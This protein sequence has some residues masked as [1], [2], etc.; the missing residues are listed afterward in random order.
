MRQWQSQ[1]HQCRQSAFTAPHS[2]YVKCANAERADQSSVKCQL[3]TEFCDTRHRFDFSRWADPASISPA[4]TLTDESSALLL[5]SAVATS[6]SDSP[7][8]SIFEQL[9]ARWHLISKLAKWWNSPEQPA[10]LL[11]ALAKSVIGH[12]ARSLNDQSQ[13]Q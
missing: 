8:D 6:P 1:R 4:H 9:L 7:I 10:S 2:R 3:Q 13:W 12:F 11:A 5:V